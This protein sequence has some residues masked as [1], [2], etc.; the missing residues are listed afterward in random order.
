VARRKTIFVAC[1]LLLLS[2]AALVAAVLLL[3]MPSSRGHNVLLIT[4]DTLRADYLGCYG[5]DSANTPNIDRLGREGLLFENAF[6]PIP[7]TLASHS[8]ILTGLYPHEHGV[9]DNAVY[10]LPE[11]IDTLGEILVDQGYET[12]AF[13]SAFVLNEQ[14][15]IAQGFAHF[16]DQ[17]DDPIESE[18]VSKR[19]DLPEYSRWWIEQKAKP[20][21]R[22]AENTATQ[23]LAWLEERRGGAPFLC[24]VHLFDPHMPYT[25]PAS[26]QEH[27]AAGE[28]G[29]G[30]MDGTMATVHEQV[31][32]NNGILR[33]GDLKRMQELYAAEVAYTDHWVGRLLAALDDL[34]VRENTLIVFASDHGESFGEHLGLFFEHNSSVFDET[35]HVPLIVAAPPSAGLASGRDAAVASLVDVT[36]T[37]LDYLEI[38]PPEVLSGCSLI[39]AHKNSGETDPFAAGQQGRKV[40]FE[41]L[42]SMQ[43]MPTPIFYK[44]VRSLDWKLFRVMENNSTQRK[45][46]RFFNVRTD[47]GEQRDL[48]YLGEQ[49]FGALLEALA[50][51]LRMSRVNEQS[52]PNFWPLNEDTERLERMRALG[53]IK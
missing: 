7:S 2:V 46:W 30:M 31:K 17:M 41:S 12:A 19:R 18:A 53:Y 15:G 23:A 22:S 50:G 5:N 51:Y 49:G 21:Q 26:W 47:P 28:P 11:E 25:P 36:P 37:I 14:F 8:S 44:G 35:L 32:A 6:T 4:I 24:W 48:S 10:F 52:P 9:R 1:A 27:L 43:A 20:F 45:V 42:C 40:Y 16:D 38:P 34:G 33:T 39:A 29:S 3:S 13:V